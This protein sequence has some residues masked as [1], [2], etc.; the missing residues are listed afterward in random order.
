M[1]GDLFEEDVNKYKKVDVFT[2]IE[3]NMELLAD[4]ILKN[5]M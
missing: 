3:P 4:Y 5:N 1:I 2:Q